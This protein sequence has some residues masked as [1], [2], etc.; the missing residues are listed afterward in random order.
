MPTEEGEQHANVQHGVRDARDD[1]GAMPQ[2]VVRRPLQGA[3]V[4]AGDG[5]RGALGKEARGG[6][7]AVVRGNAANDGNQTGPQSQEKLQHTKKKQA[8]GGDR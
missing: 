8:M 4:E 1:P 2:E 6:Q 7:E 5:G 3:R